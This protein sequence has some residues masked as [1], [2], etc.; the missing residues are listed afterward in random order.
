MGMI[1]SIIIMIMNIIMIM[2]IIII[3][4]M[5][6]IRMFMYEFMLMILNDVLMVERLLIGKFCY[7]V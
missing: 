6:S 3:M 2:D 1:M 7:L 5:V 4:N